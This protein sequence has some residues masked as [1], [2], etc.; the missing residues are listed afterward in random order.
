VTAVAISI[1]VTG[2]PDRGGQHGVDPGAL[3]RLDQH[4]GELMAEGDRHRLAGQR[5]RAAFISVHLL[6]RVRPIGRTTSTAPAGSTGRFAPRCS[7]PSTF[8]TG[9]RS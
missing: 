1:A 6:P 8:G 7:R 9:D 5:M 4:A 3:E 2:G